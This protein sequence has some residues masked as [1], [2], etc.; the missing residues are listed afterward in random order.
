ML[1]KADKYTGI[2]FAY[3]L[4]GKLLSGE[5]L[6][7]PEDGLVAVVGYGDVGFLLQTGAWGE[8]QSS[9]IGVAWLQAKIGGCYLRQVP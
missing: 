1:G 4:S 6:T 8:D 2:R 5:K 9:D 3:H 7:N